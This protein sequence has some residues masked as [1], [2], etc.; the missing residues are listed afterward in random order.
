M[1]LPNNLLN[2][3]LTSANILNSKLLLTTLDKIIYYND[4]FSY[5][6]PVENYY[7][8]YL[9]KEISLDL[10]KLI[11]EWEKSGEYKDNLFKIYNKETINILNN[12]SNKYFAQLVFPI[13]HNNCISGLFICFR[14][15]Y[16]YI[17]TSVK[18]ARTTR[19]FIE[20]MSK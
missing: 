1:N 18:P 11:K 15:S 7:N 13:Y 12:D 5:Y 16:D 9:N 20:I 2:Y 4:N 10:K 19:N 6:T 17:A 8:N 3:L 14:T